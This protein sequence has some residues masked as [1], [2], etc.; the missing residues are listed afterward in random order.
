VDTV[1]LNFVPRTIVVTILK[2]FVVK[3]PQVMTTMVYFHADQ[4]TAAHVGSIMI[5]TTVIFLIF[6]TIAPLPSILLPLQ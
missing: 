1:G 5:Y 4:K 2:E 3:T 6:Q